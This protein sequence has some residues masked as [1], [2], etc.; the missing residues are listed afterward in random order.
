MALEESLMSDIHEG[1]CA[2]GAVRFRVTGQPVVG[3]A[4]HCRFCQQRL[5][6]AFALVAYFDEKSIEFTS[7]ERS[8]YEHRSDESGRWLK[9]EFCPR[10]G[11][12]L[13]HTAEVRPGLRSIAVGTFDDPGWVRIERHIWTRSKRRW[14]QIPSDAAVFPQGSASARTA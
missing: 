2:C 10:C 1:G 3:M 14:V 9:L 13:S 5:G 11:T 4:C 6:T 7:G 12:T 8:L